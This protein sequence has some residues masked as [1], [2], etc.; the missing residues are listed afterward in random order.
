MGCVT[1]GAWD[2]PGPSQLS[3]RSTWRGG[4]FPVWKAHVVGG[5]R[6]CSE[7][8]GAAQ[9]GALHGPGGGAGA[10]PGTQ[11]R[12]RLLVRAPLTKGAPRAF[13]VL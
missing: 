12:L 10:S 11:G 5:S 7:H 13:L 8:A 3:P 4:R 6:V 9:G 2:T 1:H